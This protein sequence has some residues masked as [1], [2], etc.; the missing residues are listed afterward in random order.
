MR[1]FIRQNGSPYIQAS[2]PLFVI[3]NPGT[4]TPQGSVSTFK[5]AICKGYITYASF[6]T[7][8]ENLRSSGGNTSFTRQMSVHIPLPV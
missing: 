8:A 3:A 5:A 6:K 4:K 2:G 7:K 1:I